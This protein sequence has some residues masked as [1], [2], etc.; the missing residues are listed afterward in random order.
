M[1]GKKKYKTQLSFEMATFLK[2]LEKRPLTRYEELRQALPPLYTKY[3]LN[4]SN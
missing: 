3:N 4:K 2:T 1:H